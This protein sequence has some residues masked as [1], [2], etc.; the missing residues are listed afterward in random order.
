MA[1]KLVIEL[2]GK[3]SLSAQV[4]RL[5]GITPPAQARE[6]AVSFTTT[7]SSPLSGSNR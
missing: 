2:R 6:P 1:L 5:S 4:V 7:A 3:Q